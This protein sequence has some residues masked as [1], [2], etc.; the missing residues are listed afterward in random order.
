MAPSQAV[1][2]MTFAWRGGQYTARLAQ[3]DAD[4]TRCQ[5]LRQL[6]FFG[7]STGSDSDPFDASAQHILIT[8]E[9]SGEAVCTYRITTTC[10]A[11][12]TK[13]YAAQ[14]Y[15]LSA[16]ATQP[17]PMIELGRFCISPDTPD[18][19][20]LRVAWGA[21]TQ[22][23]DQ[24]KATFLFG[25]TSFP[26]LDPAPYGHIFVH[27]ARRHQGPADM[28][29]TKKASDTIALNTVKT[30]ASKTPLPPLLRTYLAMGGW[31]G[32]H[33]VVDPAMNTLH[34]FTALNIAAVPPARA[35]ALRAL[36]PNPD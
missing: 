24:S 27:L 12:I 7:T 30:P 23:V 36:T 18:P 22:I 2:A 21:L 5:K 3:T 17:G 9:A 28:R 14:S 8:D 32:D 26:G 20:I 13:G 1:A 19:Q 34:I 35:K 29:P 11:D 6:C 4:I 33:A 10:A 31:V 16:L 15:D 25:C